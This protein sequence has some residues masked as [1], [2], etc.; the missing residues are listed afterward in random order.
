MFAQSQELGVTTTTGQ[1]TGSHT[2]IPRF[3]DFGGRPFCD[4][5]MAKGKMASFYRTI[6]SY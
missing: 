3:H 1:D 2:Y 5:P 6:S 4:F